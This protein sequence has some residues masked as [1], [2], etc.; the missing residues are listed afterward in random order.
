MLQE[1]A[2][3]VPITIEVAMDPGVPGLFVDTVVAEAVAALVAE[4]VANT[5][6][7]SGAEGAVVRVDKLG[8]GQLRVEVSD[9]GIGFVPEEAVGAGLVRVGRRLRELG[10]RLTVDSRPWCGTRL[11]A[12]VPTDPGA[13]RV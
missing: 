4:G 11:V 13:R 7:H 8:A 10:G 1:A 6:R 2:A 5:W 12:V 9:E 3:G